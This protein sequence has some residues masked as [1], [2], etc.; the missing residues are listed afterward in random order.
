MRRGDLRS[1]LVKEGWRDVFNLYKSWIFYR[2]IMPVLADYITAINSFLV[3]MELKL[4]H[5][6]NNADKK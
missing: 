5:E 6:Q 4:H 2:S 1:P 3:P